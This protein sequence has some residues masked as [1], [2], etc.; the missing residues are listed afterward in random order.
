MAELW[1]HITLIPHHRINCKDFSFICIRK[2]PLTTKGNK[3]STNPTNQPF[4]C[5][6]NSFFPILQNQYEN[7]AVVTETA[8]WLFYLVVTPYYKKRFAPL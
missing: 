1:T 2:Y 5:R 7:K 6:I 8:I 3:I 4:P